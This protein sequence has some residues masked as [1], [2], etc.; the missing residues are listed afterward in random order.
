MRPSRTASAQWLKRAFDVERHVPSSDIPAFLCPAIARPTASRSGSSP[1]LFNL[2]ARS[3]RIQTSRLHTAPTTADIAP[4][5]TVLRHASRDLPVVCSGC[6]ALTQISEPEQA[7]YFNLERKAVQ[8]YLGLYKEEKR[9]RKEDLVVQDVLKN[10]DLAKLGHVAET[11]KSLAGATTSPATSESVASESANTPLCDRCHN[12]VHHHTGVPIYHPTI[13]SI[14]ETIEESPYKYNHVYHVIDAADFPMSLI[15]RINDLLDLMPLRSMNRRSKTAEFTRGH[16]TEVSFVITRS[17]LLAPR[18]EQVDSLMPYLTETLRSALGRKGRNIRLG[19]VWCVS[20]KRNWWTKDLKEEVWK[21]RGASWMVGKVNVGKSQLF[22]AIYP[23]GRMEWKP[24]KHEIGVEVFA[25]DKDAKFKKPNASD[26]L[27]VDD[28]SLL[29][30]PQEET[31]FPAMPVVSALPGTTASPIRVPFGNGRGELIDLPGLNRSDLEAHV[32]EEHRSSL[33]M[34]S[35]IVPEQQVIKPGQSLL[36]GGFIRITPATPGLIFL[37]YSFTPLEAHMTSTE[38]AIAVQGQTE[39]APNVENISVPGTGELIKKAGSFELCHDVTKIRAGPI[40][41]REAVGISVD[42][43]PYRVVGIDILIEGC[44]WVEIVAQVRTRDLFRQAPPEKPKRL[45][46][47]DAEIKSGRLESLDLLSDADKQEVEAPKPTQDTQGTRGTADRLDSL[48]LLSDDTAAEQAQ[49]EPAE[50]AGP[51]WPVVDVFSPNGK[52]IAA[53]RPLNGWMLNKPKKTTKSRP[54]PS[55]KGAKKR[56][57]G[58]RRQM[59]STYEE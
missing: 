11:L 56:E 41:R 46:P 38:K 18:K 39:E 53:R 55:M 34:K 58:T 59:T 29:P 17:D 4:E 7:G 9:V 36:I 12:L 47:E 24:K 28:E 23:K 33:V 42:R 6:G 22:E 10:L 37:A 51:L 27:A 57:K 8:A 31:Q 20:A 32:K 26:P 43:L 15:P 30:P 54:R 19:N 48:D 35:R 2:H 14:R 13:D 25:T 50:P 5:P 21:N 3:P 52:F 1:R 49:E 45:E 40:T 16:K 44:G